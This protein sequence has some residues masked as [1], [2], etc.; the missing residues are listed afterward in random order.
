MEIL[1]FQNDR[2]Y[3][4]IVICLIFNGLLNLESYQANS[5]ISS[6]V[7]LL[8]PAHNVGNNHDI[9]RNF[10]TRGEMNPYTLYLT[11]ELRAPLFI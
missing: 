4:Q 11:V 1:P 2:Y 3:R 8:Y 9:E 6:Q 10:L 7:K 5:L